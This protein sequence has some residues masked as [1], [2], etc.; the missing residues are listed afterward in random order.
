MAKYAMFSILLLWGG[1][2]LAVTVIVFKI[3]E[4]LLA[5]YRERAARGKRVD[6]IA[7]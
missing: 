3:G 7:T 2:W 1:A 6:R 4:R 5:R